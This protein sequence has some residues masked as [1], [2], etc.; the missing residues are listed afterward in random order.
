M[1]TREELL[2]RIPINEIRPWPA[3]RRR[4]ALI[5]YGGT[6]LAFSAFISM[7]CQ[8]QFPSVSQYLALYSRFALPAGLLLVFL[9]IPWVCLMPR[10]PTC[11]GRLDVKQWT[12]DAKGVVFPCA[13]C[14]I[15]WSTGMMPYS[16]SD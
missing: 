3:F 12:T 15:G 2:Y 9:G 6:V 5:A 10:C 16:G 14:H 11:G 1:K 4:F 8:D 13:S 7:G